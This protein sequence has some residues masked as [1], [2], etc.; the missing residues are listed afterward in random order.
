MSCGCSENVDD[1]AQVGGSLVTLFSPARHSSR[2]S[3]RTSPHA[4]KKRPVRLIGSPRASSPRSPSST[5][6]ST[7]SP[8]RSPTRSHSSS[9]DNSKSNNSSFTKPKE[10]KNSSPSRSSPSCSSPSRSQ[11]RRGVPYEERTVEELRDLV[12]TDRYNIP[13]FSTMRKAE[14]IKKLRKQH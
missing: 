7:R 3:S 2:A 6:S 12:R 1:G 5:R 8:S 4:P 9:K 14:L 13:G 10:K 11:S